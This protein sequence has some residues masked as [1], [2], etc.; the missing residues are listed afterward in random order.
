MGKGGEL[1]LTRN[2]NLAEPLVAAYAFSWQYEA[3]HRK[4][5]QIVVR[6]K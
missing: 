2:R 5:I 3:Y 6:E 1:C 4:T